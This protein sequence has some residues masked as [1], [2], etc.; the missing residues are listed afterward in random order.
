MSTEK[1]ATPAATDNSL[2]SPIKWYGNSNFCLIFKRSCLKQKSSIYTPPNRINVFIVYNL[3]TW[4]RNLNSDFTLKDCL[5]GDVKLAM[6]QVNIYSGHGIGFDSRSELS[7]PDGSVGKNVIIFRVDMSSSVHI[8]NKKKD[9]LI[10]GISSTQG[11]D[12]ATLS[13]ETQYS[14]NCSRS[15]RKIL[16]K[17]ALYW[18]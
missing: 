10:L 3:D 14:I 18:K 13:A 4:S 1:L 11:L 2:S 6:T 16:F 12:D 9:I 5:F 15:N 7:L 17:P 8:D